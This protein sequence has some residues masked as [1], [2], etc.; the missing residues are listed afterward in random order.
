MDLGYDPGIQI[1]LKI[2]VIMSD[3]RYLKKIGFNNQ[4]NSSGGGIHNYYVA[5]VVINY[6]TLHVELILHK[7]IK[8]VIQKTVQ[9][10]SSS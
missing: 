10:S 8:T 4:G 2:L 9:K 7:N 1:R 3:C 6:F 5:I